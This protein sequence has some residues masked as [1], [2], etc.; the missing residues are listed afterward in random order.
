MDEEHET[1]EKTE[2]DETIERTLKE[3]REF[4]AVYDLK[5]NL[6]SFERRLTPVACDILVLP[7]PPSFGLEWLKAALE[8]VRKAVHVQLASGILNQLDE[9]AFTHP[10]LRGSAHSIAKKLAAIRFAGSYQ[11]DGE[12]PL[13]SQPTTIHVNFGTIVC[14]TEE[15]YEA[16]HM[17]YK[18][19]TEDAL[20]KLK[21]YLFEGD[22]GWGLFEEAPLAY[23][24]DTPVT[25][26]AFVELVDQAICELPVHRNTEAAFP[27]EGIDGCI[28]SEYA[29][30]R[31]I[32]SDK[33]DR[34]LREFNG[35]K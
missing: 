10:A 33:L 26:D 23:Q 16:D 9:L 7:H 1:P 18:L 22:G 8:G 4:D 6:A 14:A 27:G 11:W 31:F 17:R 5:L 28:F 32:P 15:L 24:P 20:S 25:R 19:W 30:A 3:L 13:L 21:R 29:P 35:P 34:L 2:R 12:E